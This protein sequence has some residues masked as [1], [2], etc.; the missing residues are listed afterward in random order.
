MTKLFAAFKAFYAKLSKRE[1]LILYGTALFLGILFTDRLVLAPIVGKLSRI[2][3]EIKSQ[4]ASIKKSLHVLLRKEQIVAEGKELEKYTTSSGLPDD[5]EMTVLLKELESMA[6]KAA[7]SV[8]YVKPG[9][10][11]TEHGMKRFLASLECEAE[12][13]EVTQFFHSLESSP[14]LLQIE[15][16][17]IQQKNKESSTA[18]CTMVVSKTIIAS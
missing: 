11:E 8:V 18:R 7:V 12:M 13:R 10:I 17:E 16:Y 3:D 14:K 9:A 15:R 5:K 1:R 2:E 4:E 6:Q